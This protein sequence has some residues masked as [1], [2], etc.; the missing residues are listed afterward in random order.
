MNAL[1]IYDST[2]GNTEKIAQAVAKGLGGTASAVR[3]GSLT[4]AQW[5]GV[6]LVVLGSPTVAWKPLP[7][8]SAFVNGLAGDALKGK[9]A[10]AFDTRVRSGFGALGGLAS[11]KLTKS[12]AKLGARL[13]A[14]GESFYVTGNEGPLDAGELERA[15]TWA[16]TLLRASAER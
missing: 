16:A 13:V 7:T 9:A 6:D 2:F 8:M 5:A 11:T 14:P 10:A 3:V 15:A 4:P 12:L 1:V